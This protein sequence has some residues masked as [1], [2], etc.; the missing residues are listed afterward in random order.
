MLMAQLALALSE[1]SAKEHFASENLNGLCGQR[2]AKLLGGG[3]DQL[4]PRVG[5]VNMAP[6]AGSKWT[7]VML[8]G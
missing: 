7:S 5:M 1:G 2:A 3:M 4:L 8:E 6:R